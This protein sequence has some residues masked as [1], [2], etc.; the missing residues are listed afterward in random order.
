MS[1]A[2]ASEPVSAARAPNGRSLWRETGERFVR[3]RAAMA[4]IAVVSLLVALAALG[5]FLWPHGAGAIDAERIAWAP[6]TQHLHVLGTDAEGRDMVA[7]LLTGLG[8]SLL[9]G[10]LA[11]MLSSAAGVAYGAIAGFVGGA[12]DAILM[13]VVD[14]LASVPL[15]LLAI[16]LVVA[17]PTQ[18]A[19]QNVMLVVIAIAAV[20]WLDMARLVRNR[21]SALRRS[22]FVEAARAGGASSVQIA[23]RHVAPNVLGPIVL[24]AVL[25]APVVVFLESVLSFLGFG[26]K[27]PLASLGSLIAEGTLDMAAAPWMLLAPA[28][29]LS[30]TLLALN[31]VGDGLREALDPRARQ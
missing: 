12:L 28:A 14:A 25:S 6:T 26:V 1:E 18:D 11:T 21:I 27:E 13:R 2:A 23:F 16:L 24:R 4:C 3:N 31:G 9:V 30:V 8:A 5:P 15:F 29:T 20:Q 10:F 19:M 22:A 7:R 17:I